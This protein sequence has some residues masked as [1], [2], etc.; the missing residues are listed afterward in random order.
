MKETH[1]KIKF[2]LDGLLRFKKNFA[3]DSIKPK[4]YHVIGNISPTRAWQY[5][6]RYV[7]LNFFKTSKFKRDDYEGDKDKVIEYYNSQGYRDAYIVRDTTY[8]I[9]GL[10]NKNM[11]I[12]I[13]VN[14][15]KK[16]Y[17][18][19]IYFNGNTKYPDSLLAKII[20]IKRGEVYNQKLLDERIFMNPNGGDLS[21]LYMDD[22]YL[23]FSVTPME[24]KVEGDSIDLNYVLMKA[25]RLPYARCAL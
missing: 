8:M 20:N 4:W 15:G 14:E 5:M 22:G 10:V 23:F 11:N 7:N 12:D 2:D 21:S 25:H 19:N 18:R 9:D 3:R 16:Y 17:F 1:E 6:D 13:Y 24:V